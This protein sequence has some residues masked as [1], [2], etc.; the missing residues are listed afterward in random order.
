M[1]TAIGI[2]IPVSICVILPIIIVWIVFNFLNNR[3]NRQSDIILEVIKNNPNIDT[4]KLLQSLK[5]TELT[6]LDYVNRKLLRGCIFTLLGITFALIS[7]L[8]PENDEVLGCWVA[9]GVF[10]SVGIG[11]LIS[12][13]FG[14]KHIGNYWLQRRNNN[15]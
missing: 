9:C 8:V 15:L 3:T 2:V 11:F 10:G 7:A 14:Y 5:K 6:P 13:W 4:E 12:Y 1:E